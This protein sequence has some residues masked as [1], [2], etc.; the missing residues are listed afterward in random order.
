LHAVF[1]WKN[2]YSWASLCLNILFFYSTWKGL[3]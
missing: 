3:M 2:M 1:W